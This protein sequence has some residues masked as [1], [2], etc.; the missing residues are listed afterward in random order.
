M[1]IAATQQIIIRNPTLPLA[2]YRELTAHLHQIDGLE[3]TD[4]S[5][6]STKFDYS[7]SQISG[8][9]IS[10]SESVSSD[11]KAKIQKILTFY[12]NKYGEWQ[13]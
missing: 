6:E 5:Q 1:S 2:I 3:I 7:L 11:E 13:I 4:I 10:V 8:L 9:I 12:G